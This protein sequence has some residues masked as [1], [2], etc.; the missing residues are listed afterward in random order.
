MIYLA[1]I[2]TTG[3]SVYITRIKLKNHG[4]VKMENLNNLY[5][6]NELEVYDYI[7]FNYIWIMSI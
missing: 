3:L 5:T 4:T 6:L 7:W 2:V 1:V